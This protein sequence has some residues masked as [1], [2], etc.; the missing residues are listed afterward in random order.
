MKERTQVI[1]SWYELV[2]LVENI[3]PNRETV[4]LTGWINDIYK[5]KT[6]IQQLIFTTK[7][8]NI[9]KTTEK[10]NGNI[11]MDKKPDKKDTNK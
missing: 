11:R 6:Y 7:D 5:D 8:V 1:S 4:C 2:K 10:K 3:N 9:L